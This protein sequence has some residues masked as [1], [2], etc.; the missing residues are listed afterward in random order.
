MILDWLRS[1]TPDTAYSAYTA[2]VEQARQPAFYINSA[3][4]DT[5]DGRFDMIVMHIVLVFRRFNDGADEARAFGQH[6]F[7]I[8][9]KDMDRSLREIGVG[10]VSI[11]KKM[12]KIGRSYYGRSDVYVDALERRDAEA[13]ADA[14]DRNIFT[15]ETNGPASRLLAGYMIRADEL[16]AGQP[17]SDLMAGNF[18]WPDLEADMRDCSQSTLP[19]A[20]QD[21]VENLQAAEKPTGAGTKR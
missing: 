1:K 16:L 18:V 19:D 5:L 7:D 13:L 14:I 9:I 3:V 8:F 2:L 6:I 21:A 12:K 10:D 17:V 15:D 20:D 11:P 4:P